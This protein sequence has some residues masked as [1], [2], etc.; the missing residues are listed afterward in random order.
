[1]RLSPEVWF[2]LLGRR[3]ALGQE[4]TKT[5]AG[6]SWVALDK[7]VPLPGIQQ[8]KSTL[9]LQ[10]QKTLWAPTCGLSSAGHKVRKSRWIT[11]TL[12]FQVPHHRFH[13]LSRRGVGF[14]GQRSL[15]TVQQNFIPEEQV[16]QCCVGSFKIWNFK[17]QQ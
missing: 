12:L 4:C 14:L 9:L 17:S 8:E 16:G 7:I 5:C 3:G 13:A 2:T 10:V 1:M 11:R 15:V 6:I